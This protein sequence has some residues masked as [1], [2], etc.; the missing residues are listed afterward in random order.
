[1]FHA[2]QSQAAPGAWNISRIESPPIVPDLQNRAFTCGL[3]RDFNRGA[4]S[5]LHRILHSLVSNMVKSGSNLGIDLQSRVGVNTHGAGKT[6]MDSS[7]K[8][9]ERGPQAGTLYR[10]RIQFIA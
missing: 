7:S 5:M 2:Q 8:A 3:Y 9:V 4:R 6:R 10:G 1:M